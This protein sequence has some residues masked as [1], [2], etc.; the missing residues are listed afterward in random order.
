MRIAFRTDAQSSTQGGVQSVL[1]LTIPADHE[2]DKSGGETP[3]D[4]GVLPREGNSETYPEIT[5]EVESVVLDP[6]FPDQSVQVGATL[7]PTVKEQVIALL[8]KYKE[9]FAWKTEDMPGVSPELI[10]HKLNIDPQVKPVQQKRRNFAPECSSLRTVT[11]EVRKLWTTYILKKVFYPTWLS[12]LVM[13][14][15]PDNSWRMCVDYTDLNKFC[16]KH[17]SDPLPVIDQ[18]VEAISGYE[19]LMFLD[20]Y[21]G[22]HQILMAEEDADKMA[23]I[24]DIGVFCYK[25]MPFGLKNAG[26]TYQRMMDRVFAHQIGRNL[27]VYVDDMVIKCRTAQDAPKELEE[28]LQTLLSVNLRLNPKK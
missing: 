3:T 23:F 19:V 14:K 10:V 26:A 7:P 5:D 18:K 22:Y 12:N 15:K 27:E 6:N 24:T 21:K 13:V 16:P 8:R 1:L 4:P 20:A 9:V 11:D 25:K 2:S 28:T 17:P